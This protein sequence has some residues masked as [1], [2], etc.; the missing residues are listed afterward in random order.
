MANGVTCDYISKAE[1]NFVMLTSGVVVSMSNAE[2]TKLYETIIEEVISDSRQDFEDSGIDESTLQELRRVWCE[3]LSQSGVAKFTWDDEIHHENLGHGHLS[4]Q[5]SMGVLAPDGLLALD[6]SGGLELPTL[7]YPTATGDRGHN[8]GMQLQLPTVL[9][10]DEYDDS[11]GLM[12]PRV[13]QTDGQF[14]L[15]FETSDAKQLMKKFQVGQAD[16]EFDLDDG[17]DS[18]KSEGEEGYQEGQI[19]LCLYD[20]VQRVK[21]KWKLTLKEGI[22]NIGGRDYV[23]QKASGENEW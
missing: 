5:E 20:K 7:S 10:N 23:F 9:G 15:T 17:S 22:A 13:N 1:P 4:V 18:D 6:S 8:S 16:G 2:A 19:M 14:E 3:K 12:L 21:N 11:T